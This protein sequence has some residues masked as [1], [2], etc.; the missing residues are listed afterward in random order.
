MH[1][2]TQRYTINHLFV[3]RVNT[4]CTLSRASLGAFLKIKSALNLNTTTK[5]EPKKSQLGMYAMPSS[6]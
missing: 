1:F 5:A 4:L 2:I 3:L 6:V